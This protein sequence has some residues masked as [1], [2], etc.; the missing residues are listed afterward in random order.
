[1]RKTTKQFVEQATTI[2]G[3]KYDYSRVNY[4]NVKTKVEIVCSIHGSFWVRP[5]DHLAKKSGCPDCS[6][7]RKK[8][9]AEFIDQSR[10]IHG[11]VYQYDKT[12]Y[13][14]VHKKVS[15]TCPMH[16][17]FEVTP[18]DHI[19][20]KI[21]CKECGKIRGASKRKLST[22]EF[23]ERGTLIHGDKY[24]YSKV[25]Y[26]NNKTNVAII[27]PK[28]GEFLQTPTC[29]I[30]SRQGCPKCGNNRKD[31]LGGITEAYLNDNP[32]VANAPAILYVVEM[33]HRMDSFIKVGITTRTVE[34]RF[35]TRSYSTK[36]ERI[37]L[38]SIPTTLCEAFSY[39]Q[40][41]LTQ[42]NEYQYWP[43]YMIDGKTECLKNNDDVLSF[44]E[45]FLMGR[46]DG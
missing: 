7:K 40:H 11:D 10:M 44:I 19:V 30:D 23:I 34:Q 42:L 39:E 5:N 29:H 27:C 33:K 6:G 14:G 16:G 31:G 3:D 38:Y 24:D 4:I 18:K 9:T 21:G 45:K 13:I 41:I 26:V 36:F 1:M 37:V 20:G 28:H 35:R 2:H 43:N 25:E 22:I 46:K 32:D 15:I 12:E 17:D 8:T